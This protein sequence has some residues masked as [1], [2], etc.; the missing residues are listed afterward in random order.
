M[1]DG[2]TSSFAVQAAE[3]RYG[4]AAV[5]S[6]LGAL[7]SSGL[8]LQRG[9]LTWGSFLGKLMAGLGA[10][11]GLVALAGAFGVIKDDDTAIFIAIAGGAWPVLFMEAFRAWGRARAKRH[12]LVLRWVKEGDDGNG[13]KKD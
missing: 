12:G 8:D 3:A 9:Q 6:L 11:I 13:Q 4:I 10:G 2:V 1:D 7:M 5:G